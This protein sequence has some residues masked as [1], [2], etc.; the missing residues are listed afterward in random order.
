MSTIPLGIYIDANGVPQTVAGLNRVAKAADGITSNVSKLAGMFGVAFGGAAILGFARSITTMASDLR[1]ASEITGLN[2]DALQGLDMVARESGG[3]VD[4]L[5]SALVKLRKSQDDLG[6][7]EVTDALKR[8]GLTAEQVAGSSMQ[9][10]VEALAKGYKSTGDLDAVST[11]AGRNVQGFEQALQRVADGGMSALAEAAKAAGLSLDQNVAARADAA[12][13]RLD[14][15]FVRLRVGAANVLSNT[16]DMLGKLGEGWG[17]VI[18]D[19]GDADFDFLR[20]FNAGVKI[21]SDRIEAETQA[22]IDQQQAMDDLLAKRR[23][24]DL[25]ARNA[26]EL[27]KFEADEALATQQA[28]AEMVKHETDLRKRM[29]AASRDMPQMMEQSSAGLSAALARFQLQMNGGTDAQSEERRQTGYLERITR[30]IERD[31]VT[32]PLQE[33]E[34]Y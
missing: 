17:N 13:E 12:G 26:A 30:A 4:G 6:S 14:R 9:E 21:A 22:I 8:L 5:R 34:I 7:A 2:T 3:N 11:L 33:V 27:R 23:T 32:D 28:I 20:S 19:M 31:T 24:A 18:A 29:A 16:I 15:L 10:Y 1:D 25:E